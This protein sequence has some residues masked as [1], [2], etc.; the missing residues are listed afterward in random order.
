M[1]SIRS[2]VSPLVFAMALGL[3]ATMD[4]AQAGKKGQARKAVQVQGKKKD[5][6]C[7]EEGFK[8]KKKGRNVFCKKKVKISKG[9]AC[10]PIDGAQV[11]QKRKKC[12]YFMAPVGASGA[13]TGGSAAFAD[14]AAA[15]LEGSLE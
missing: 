5:F 13:D 2:F 14:E 9:S 10:E 11:I 12:L 8:L 1:K 15:D 3:G 6:S 7:S 4:S